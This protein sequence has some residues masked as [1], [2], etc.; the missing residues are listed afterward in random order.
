LVLININTTISKM[1]TIASAEA[2]AYTYWT[3]AADPTKGRN[4]VFDRMVN[5]E[6]PQGVFGQSSI[7]NGQPLPHSFSDGKAI[8]AIPVAGKSSKGEFVLPP[9]SV[10]FAVSPKCPRGL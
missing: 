4:A 1:V 6:L 3:L 10:T 5:Q 8:D 7:L 9:F 2:S